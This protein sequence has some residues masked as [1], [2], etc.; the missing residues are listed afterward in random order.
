MGQWKLGY[1]QGLS[2]V[3]NEDAGK[4]LYDGW[5]IDPITLSMV[6]VSWV[7]FKISGASSSSIGASSISVGSNA[8][9]GGFLKVRSGDRKG[10]A[11]KITSNG[12][13]SFSVKNFDGTSIDATG[14]VGC[15]AEAVSGPGTFTFP[16]GRNPSK[17]DIKIATAGEFEQFPYYTGGM[18]IPVNY[19]IDMVVDG[20]MT[21]REQLEKLMMFCKLKVDY[22]GGDAMSTGNMC[23][24]MVL[25]TGTHDA[26]H[27]Y[28]V[29]CEEAKEI[30]E[31]SRGG[32]IQIQMYLKVL[33]LPSYRGI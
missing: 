17:K 22:A 3:S 9:F 1:P 19:E 24:P 30:T 11:F 31:G 18:V 33:E 27:Q 32:L 4:A 29:H 12:A 20:W 2:V 28:L 16:L 6:D 5:M 10:D 15:Y 26:S 23:A 21:S 7:G 25:E 14:L 13:S 8:F